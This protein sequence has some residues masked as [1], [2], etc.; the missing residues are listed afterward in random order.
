MQ[1]SL[2]M[3]PRDCPGPL[4]SPTLAAKDGGTAFRDADMRRTAAQSSEGDASQS[5][6]PTADSR[7]AASIIQRFGLNAEQAAALQAIKAWSIAGA[8]QVLSP[9][10]PTQHCSSS[11][12]SKC[13][14]VALM[15]F[16]GSGA[17]LQASGP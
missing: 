1:S 16:S 12:G 6:L 7:D 2:P 13:F 10:H 17:T 3:R 11:R 9:C 4:V 5:A 8:S 15:R 14:R